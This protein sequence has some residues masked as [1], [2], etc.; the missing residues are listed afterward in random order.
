MSQLGRR[1]R[2]FLAEAAFNWVE[3]SVSVVAI[4]ARRFLL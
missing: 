3:K 1:L 4:R 2:N